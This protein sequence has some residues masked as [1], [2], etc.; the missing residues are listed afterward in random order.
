M[1]IAIDRTSK[2]AY[3]ELHNSA[4]KTVAAEFLRKN[5]TIHNTYHPY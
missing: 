3:V 1:F 5:F 4:T 2:F